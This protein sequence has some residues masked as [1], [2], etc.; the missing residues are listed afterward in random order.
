[1]QR[2]FSIEEYHDR[3]SRTLAVMEA[4]GFETAVVV[5]RGGATTDNCGDILYLT[6]AYS[7]RARPASLT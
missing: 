5:D 1:M 4:H 2:Y 7:D 3:W 6:T